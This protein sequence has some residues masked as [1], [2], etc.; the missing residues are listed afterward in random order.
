VKVFLQLAVF[1]ISVSS[2]LSV[3]AAGVLETVNGDVRVGISSGAATAAKVSQRVTRATTIVTGP[4]SSAQIRFEDG[5]VIAVH[6]NSDFRI[7]EYSFTKDQ[8]AKDKFSFELAK[9]ALRSVTAAT[10]RRT[11]DAYT[12]KTA[13][14]TMGIRGTDFLV[15]IVNPVYFQVING[16]VTVTNT[17]GVAAFGAG[18]A[19]TVATG[20][21]LAVTIPLSALPASV[22][23]TFSQLAGLTITV[24]GSVGAAVAS[25]QAAGAITPAMGIAIGAAALAAGLVVTNANK[26]D[27]VTSVTTSP[28]STTTSTR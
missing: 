24:T 6:E 2:A 18:A 22:A 4:K 15:A 21:S 25:A 13:T 7:S 27:D 11:P 19:G 26:E 1:L 20:A 14:A 5:Q 9:G 17:A 16:A 28:S 12:L 23:A 8:P 3:L 10:T